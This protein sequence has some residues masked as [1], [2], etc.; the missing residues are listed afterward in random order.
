M[1]HVASVEAARERLMR[2]MP[3]GNRGRSPLVGGRPR[4]HWY[5]NE[6]AR[7][8]LMIRVSATQVAAGQAL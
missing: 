5:T 8:A 4:T 1:F 3:L 6:L 2:Q 7:G